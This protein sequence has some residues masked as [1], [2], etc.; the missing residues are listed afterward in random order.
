MVTYSQSGF[1]LLEPDLAS[2]NTQQTDVYLD[3]SPGA[4]IP[5]FGPSR[6]ATPDTS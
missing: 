1:G 4:E 2:Q 5:M 6:H 3:Y